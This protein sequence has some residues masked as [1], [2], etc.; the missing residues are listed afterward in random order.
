MGNPVSIFGG[1]GGVAKVGALGTIGAGE[2]VKYVVAASLAAD[3]TANVW[4]PTGG[5]KFVL[6]GAYVTASGGGLVEFQDGTTAF[7]MLGVQ[8]Q[9]A[10][11]SIEFPAG[12]ESA[13]ADNVLKVKNA[14]SGTNTLY[15]TVWGIEK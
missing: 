7:A 8:A 3:A 13:A 1:S 2:I 5:K 9:H 14:H 12:Y 15:V 4:V 6:G 11:S 10:N